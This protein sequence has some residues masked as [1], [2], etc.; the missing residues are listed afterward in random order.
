M[1]WF[2]MRTTNRNFPFLRNGGCSS[3]KTC[4]EKR[5]W[6]N[7]LVRLD[8]KHYV[9]NCCWTSFPEQGTCQGKCTYKHLVV[10]KN[11]CC[12]HQGKHVNTLSIITHQWKTVY[13]LQLNKKKL[14]ILSKAYSY[15]L[16]PFC[17]YREN[18]SS[19]FTHTY[20]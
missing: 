9:R 11:W 8:T 12:S 20:R 16:R 7:L 14:K 1:L 6:Q 4:H 2:P 15:A 18:T 10:C 5:Q 17:S 13:P 19:T 3:R